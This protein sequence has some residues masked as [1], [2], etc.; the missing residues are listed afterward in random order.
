MMVISDYHRAFCAAFDRKDVAASHLHNLRK[1]K[2]WK[3]G[4]APER[5]IGRH[6][7][8]SEAEIAWLQANCTLPIAEYHNSFCTKF[9]RSDVT[10][11]QLYVLRKAKKWKTGRT[12]RFDK[13]HTT[14]SKGKKLGNNPGSA[15]TQFKKCGLPHNTKFTG[16]ERVTNGY[17]WI[18]VDEP[19][20]YTG[21]ERRYIQKH[22]WLWEQAHGQI[23]EGM[24][25]KCRGD[26]LNTD[27]SNWELVPR[28]LLPRLNGRSGRNYDTAPEELKPTIMAVAKLEHRLRS[29]VD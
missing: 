29:V 3:V 4:R 22:R 9:E 1:R 26:A 13:G 5:Y 16:H 20:P 23:P 18:S 17:V 21:F 25:L 7:K 28:G 24:C 19:N 14:W 27:P 11:Q 2:G 6:R 8:Y 10:A 15:R 12:G